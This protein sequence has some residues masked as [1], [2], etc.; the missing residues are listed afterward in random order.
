MASPPKPTAP[1]LFDAMREDFEGRR[2]RKFAAGLLV[3]LI[4]F[5]ESLGTPA[6]K[7]SGLEDFYASFPPQKTTA[8]GLGANTLIVTKPGGGTDS[9]RPYYNR[10]EGF[11][12]NEQKRYD[13]PSAAPHATQAWK[14]YEAWIGL[15]ATFDQKTLTELRGKVVAYVLDK[16][17]SQEIDPSEIVKDPPVFAIF[18]NDF[19]FRATGKGEATG[20]GFQGAVFAYIRAD[21]PHLQ[22]E[23]DK[24]RTGSKR[25]HRVGD[26]DAWDGSRL[27]KTCEV[28][29]FKVM[30]KDAADYTAF[31]G[32][33]AKR[34]A[35][36]YLVAEDFEE[37]ARE[38]IESLGIRTMTLIDL[39]HHVSVWD[40]LKQQ[41]A[42]QAFEYFITHREQ[43]SSL[44][45]R[46]KNF[47]LE[48]G[49]LHAWSRPLVDDFGDQIG[50]LILDDAWKAG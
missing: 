38:R 12:R 42:L 10:I 15:L 7:L 29:H 27:V 22:V 21:S 14:D 23:V 49:F 30:A 35:D 34:R 43:N 17:P 40:P 26:V 39:K 44:A 32:E 47:C 46:F 37:G 4:D 13:F 50:L 48:K 1:D 45:L 18:L 25:V 2:R 8:Q 11:F 6:M 16:L 5:M 3:A 9:I 36:A 19:D 28:K 31:A 20:S 33:A 24:T 41:I